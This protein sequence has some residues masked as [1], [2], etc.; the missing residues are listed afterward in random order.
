MKSLPVSAER[1]RDVL[2]RDDEVLA[3]AAEDQ[4]AEQAASLP[5]WMTSLPSPPCMLVVAAHDP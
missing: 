1:G 5:A 4:V 3:V 2:G